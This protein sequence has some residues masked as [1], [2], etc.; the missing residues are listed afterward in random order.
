MGPE[1]LWRT[2]FVYDTYRREKVRSGCPGSAQSAAVDRLPKA[3]HP[4]ETGQG[5]S[6]HLWKT[7]A[8]CLPTSLGCG[9][10]Q[11]CPQCRTAINTEH[12]ARGRHWAHS[13]RTAS[14]ATRRPITTREDQQVRLYPYSVR[15]RAEWIFRGRILSLI[16]VHAK[17]VRKAH[18]KQN[19]LIFCF[20]LH[21]IL[22]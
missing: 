13:I 17:V 2:V 5:W 4:Q 19:M 3:R 15:L 16:N 22:L 14:T 11:S 20:F 6:G 12:L 7:Q 9:T 21:N 18:A 10:C 1:K 8:V